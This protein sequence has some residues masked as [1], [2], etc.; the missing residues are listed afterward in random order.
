MAAEKR[1]RATKKEL[2]DLTPKIMAFV[3]EGGSKLQASKR[4]GLSYATVM[5]I[6]AN[7]D[8]Y[9]A[10]GASASAS[11]GGSS[12]SARLTGGSMYL[13]VDRT[14]AVREVFSTGEEARAYVKGFTAAGG[15]GLK[16]LRAAEV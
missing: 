16:L 6:V 2:I 7:A 14:N 12:S 13:I 4:F 9:M 10:G 3:N 11:S 15:K 8:K 1:K 5:R